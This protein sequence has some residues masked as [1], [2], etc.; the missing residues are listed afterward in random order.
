MIF[1]CAVSGTLALIFPSL[2]LPLVASRADLSPLEDYD[3]FETFNDV[4]T[5]PNIFALSSEPAVDSPDRLSQGISGLISD[6]DTDLWAE[7]GDECSTD[8]QS[9]SNVQKRNDVCTNLG[10]LNEPGKE[11]SVSA[12]GKGAVQ[13]V[14]SEDLDICGK[15][16]FLHFFAVC[17][18]G[19][20][21]DTILNIYTGEYSLI[22]C[23]RGKLRGSVFVQVKPI[24]QTLGADEARQSTYL[25]S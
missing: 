21:D 1:S 16:D 10:S 13:T 9:R 25:P 11:S 14:T 7:V 22:D 8:I 24:T 18:S 12:I 2:I 19:H 3:V 20:E 5:E 4:D 6:P 17:E 15:L 23:E